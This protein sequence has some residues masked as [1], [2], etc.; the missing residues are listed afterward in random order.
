MKIRKRLNEKTKWFLFVV[1]NFIFLIIC[2]YIIVED[3]FK[4]DYEDEPN[5]GT[6]TYTIFIENRDNQEIEFYLPLPEDENLHDNIH[7]FLE[8]NHNKDKKTSFPYSINSSDYGNC[9][10]VIANCSFFIESSYY[11]QNNI[12][13]STLLLSTQ[14]DDFVYVGVLNE[15]PQ[16]VSILLY[17]EVYWKTGNVY[18]TKYKYVSI[19]REP[20]IT[21]SKVTDKDSHLYIGGMGFNR[22]GVVLYSGWNNVSINYNVFTHRT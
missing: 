20:Y 3:I 2:G 8:K 18:D 11:D 21:P 19:S 15:K 10:K 4:G 14:Q 17:Y 13:D 16:N 22:E 9:L 1:C 7:F 5:K 12:V 6:Y